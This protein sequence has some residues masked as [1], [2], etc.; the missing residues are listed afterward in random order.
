MSTSRVIIK[1][2]TIPLGEVSNTTRLRKAINR[3]RDAIMM[4][5]NIYE[6]ENK[7]LEDKREVKEK[8]KKAMKE[9][10]IKKKEE[11]DDRLFF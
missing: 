5:E 9:F 3:F 7:E 1:E 2:K 8:A 11:L 4:D 10:R 6:I